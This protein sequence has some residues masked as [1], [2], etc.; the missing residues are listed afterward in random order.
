MKWA[1]EARI[2][3]SLSLSFRRPLDLGHDAVA[4][5]VHDDIESAE[6]LFDFRK[7]GIYLLDGRDIEWEDEQLRRRVFL[8]VGGEDLGAAECGNDALVCC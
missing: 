5:V 1:P 4:S 7:S 2:E 8:R 6:M 3:T